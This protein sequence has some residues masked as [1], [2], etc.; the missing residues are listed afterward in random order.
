MQAAYLPPI[1][2]K[3]ELL[4]GEQYHDGFDT[5]AY[6]NSRY[7]TASHPLFTPHLPHLHNVYKTLG[8]NKNLKI[9][10]VGSG[11]S[12]SNIISAAPYAS[13]IV[14]AEYTENNRRVLQQ[15]LDRE[16]QAFD[17][18]TFMKHVVVDVEGG[19][20]KDV[21]V[22]EERIRSSVKAVI[23]CDV[24]KDP[25]LPQQYI[26]QYDIVQSMLCL[27][28]ACQT[29]EEYSAA[30][31][32]LT[33]VLKPDGKLILY[34]VE[35]DTTHLKTGYL[36]GDKLFECVDI[37]KGFITESLTAIGF[38]DISRVSMKILPCIAGGNDKDPRTP[39]LYTAT[40]APPLLCSD[41]W[42][43]PI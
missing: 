35:R 9:L 43:A 5:Q 2:K 29:E 38:S 20:E 1:I 25:L 32:R 16:P 39:T 4:S 18:T 14:L 31:K 28:A 7:S 26:G 34:S 22:R 10:E 15:W 19:E 33:Q 36:V 30:I 37:S 8:A 24:T 3:M 21:A 41:K 6:L 42:T 12:I 27:D 13:E 40:Y 23:P 11:P 17:W